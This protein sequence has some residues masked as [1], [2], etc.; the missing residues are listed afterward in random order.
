MADDNASALSGEQLVKMLSELDPRRVGKD[1]FVGLLAAVD[2]LAKQ[3][4]DV[5]LSRLDAAAFAR[6]ITR[7]SNDQLQGVLGR[8]D[9]RSVI[10]DEIFRRMVDHLR[11]ERVA[12]VSAVVHWR[13]T[14]GT[15]DGGFDR[16][17]TII[18]H[19]TCVV[20]RDHAEGEPRVTITLA[21]IDFVKLVTRNVSGP[22][23]FMTGK[24]KIKGDLAFAAG[25]TNL[26]DLP[27]A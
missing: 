9:L 19:G 2:R 4:G 15:G 25:M 22:V 20:R 10:I 7:A 18:E 21:P 11:P 14:G 3:G 24:L 26:F 16:Y 1:D 6:L 13:L 5:D 17:E 23:L 12:N 27:R 8:P